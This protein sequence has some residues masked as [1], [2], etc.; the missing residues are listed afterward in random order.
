MGTIRGK[1]RNKA[2]R[3]RRGKKPVTIHRV[4]DQTYLADSQGRRAPS[5][6]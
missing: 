1:S 2:R 4:D 3:D 5:T 6:S